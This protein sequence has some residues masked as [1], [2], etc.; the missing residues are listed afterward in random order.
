[1]LKA[2][3]IGV[4]DNFFDIGGHSLLAMQVIARVREAFQIEMR[5]RHLFEAPTLGA[6]AQ[7]IEKLTAQ[8]DKSALPTITRAVRDGYKVKLPDREMSRS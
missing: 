8:V 7:R 1:V 3:R 6:L 4:H 5:V 2:D